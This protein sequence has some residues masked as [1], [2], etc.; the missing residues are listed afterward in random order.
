MPLKYRR[1]GYP[2]GIVYVIGW[3]A[4]WREQIPA[5]PA[6]PADLDDNVQDAV[7]RSPLVYERDG[8]QVNATLSYLQVQHGRKGPVG[9]GSIVERDTIPTRRG[10]CQVCGAHRDDLI[11]R[12]DNSGITGWVCQHHDALDIVFA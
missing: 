8:Q 12:M 5:L 4:D 7:V 2:S 9:I 3:W 10:T 1:T 6:D 11:E